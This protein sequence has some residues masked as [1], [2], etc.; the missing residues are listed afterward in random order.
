[1]LFVKLAL[2]FVETIL[3][4]SDVCAGQWPSYMQAYIFLGS[5]L[6][7]SLQIQASLRY[8]LFKQRLFGHEKPV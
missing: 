3:S 1:M 4:S 2:M 5:I 8:N 6:T 7:G